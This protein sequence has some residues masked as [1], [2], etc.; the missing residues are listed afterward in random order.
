MKLPKFYNPFKAHIVQASNGKYFVRRHR[1]LYWE[2]KD[3][4]KVYLKEDDW[5]STFEYAKKW[6]AVDTLEEAK[7]LLNEHK[8]VK[9]KVIHG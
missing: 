6:C 5:W 1:L 3:N 7:S 9:F 2:Y 4:Q 8:S